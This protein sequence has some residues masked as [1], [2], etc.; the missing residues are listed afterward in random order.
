M[1]NKFFYPLRLTPHEGFSEVLKLNKLN[2]NFLGVEVVTSIQQLWDFW[3]LILLMD[4]NFFLWD[5]FNFL[6]FMLVLELIYILLRICRCYEIEN[7]NL[8]F[9]RK[10]SNKKLFYKKIIILYFIIEIPQKLQKNPI[11]NSTMLTF[12]KRQKFLQIVK[13]IVFPFSHERVFN[14]LT[15]LHHYY[16]ILTLSL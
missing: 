7:P 13:K 16:N 8:I 2:F 4:V 14:Y 5:D 15:L 6:L 12:I 3:T 11:H 9:F 10:S 1:F